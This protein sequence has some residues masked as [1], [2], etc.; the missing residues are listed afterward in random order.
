MARLIR[1]LTLLAAPLMLTSCLLVPTKFASTLDIGADRSFTFSYV[2]EVQLLKMDAP[3][4]SGEETDMP[5]ED[6]IGQE[7]DDGEPRLHPVA[8][9][10]SEGPSTDSATDST[11]DSTEDEA[12]IKRLADALAKEYGFRSVHYL[13]R[14][15]LAIDYRIS[16]R[17]DHGFVFPFNPDGE[18]IVPFL[19][20]ELRGKDRV[21]VKA[22]G[23][24]NDSN[25]PSSLGGIGGDRDANPGAHLDG[26]FTLTTNAEI[27]SQNQ[28]DGS[29]ATADGKRRI[30]W[31]ITPDTRD[32][33]MAVLRVQPLP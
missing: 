11:A 4:F 31:A 21:R 17:L 15:T 14:R 27:V 26:Q 19:A 25:T 12:R 33:P 9:Q 6:G 29:E 24:A 3:D 13:G 22:P 18:A 23:F 8:M 5:G 28:E 20:I 2:G 10:T 1:C 16:G 30:S 32:A 7:G